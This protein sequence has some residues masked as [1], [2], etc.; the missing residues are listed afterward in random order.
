MSRTNLKAARAAQCLSDMLNYRYL[1]EEKEMANRKTAK[2]H[3]LKQQKEQK[4]QEQA[5]QYVQE[6]L[7][8]K[9]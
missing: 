7:G 1:K 9:K 3:R 2:K 6:K 4:K 8:G 5:L